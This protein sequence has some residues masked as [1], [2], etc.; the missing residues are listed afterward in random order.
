MSD[1]KYRVYL[2]GV[3]SEDKITHE[4]RKE[5]AKKLGSNF[6]VDDPTS[7]KFDKESWKEAS[8]DSDKLHEIYELHQTEILLPKSHQSVA[9]ADIILANLAIEASD[10]PMI[11]SI[12]EIAWAYHQNKTVIA[13]RGSSYYSKHPMIRGAVQAWVDSVEEACILVKEFFSSKG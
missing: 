12:M 11:G 13:I 6:V 2:V 4:W 9:K 7:T 3:I 8:G 1:G 10:R 5:A